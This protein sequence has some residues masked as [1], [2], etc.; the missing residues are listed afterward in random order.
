[1]SPPSYHHPFPNKG[2]SIVPITPNV[3]MPET[4]ETLN[5]LLSHEFIHVLSFSEF[6]I[7]SY[8][9]ANETTDDSTRIYS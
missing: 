8:A 7:E 3:M 4:D 5:Y 9:Y 1:M 2:M 6:S